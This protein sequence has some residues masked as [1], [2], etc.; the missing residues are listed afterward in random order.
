MLE[1]EVERKKKKNNAYRLL[2]DIHDMIPDADER[3]DPP[4]AFISNPPR[5]LRRRVQDLH[6]GEELVALVS[7][8]IWESWRL[9]RTPLDRAD[10]LPG[11][12]LRFQR[13]GEEVSLRSL[14]RFHTYLILCHSSAENSP[15]YIYV[16][17]SAPISATSCSVPRTPSGRHTPPHGANNNGL[18]VNII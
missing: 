4:E 6:L 10:A 16:Y 1:N 7:I 8:S 18:Q 17:S 3:Q 5:F 13:H 14:R 15:L 2:V 9:L 11:V 12:V